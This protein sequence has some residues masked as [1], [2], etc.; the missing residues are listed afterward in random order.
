M[1]YPLKHTEF[2]L[3]N[4]K[5]KAKWS[6]SMLKFEFGEKS[7][8]DLEKDVIYN[9]MCCSCGA[10]AGF[11]NKIEIIDEVATGLERCTTPC[12]ICYSICPRTYF[13][14]KALDNFTF[15]MYRKDPA[16]GYYEKIVMARSTD[17]ELLKVAQNGGVVTS[18]L[19]WALENNEIDSA[20]VARSSPKDQ[21]KPTPVV[22]TTKEE[23]LNAAGSCYTA[24]P[25][26]KGIA[27]AISLGM[28]KIGWVGVPCQVTAFRK[29]QSNKNYELCAENVALTIGLF[30]MET[31]WYKENIQKF[32]KEEF[33][34]ISAVKKFDVAKGKF[35]VY[36]DKEK[37]LFPIKQMDKYVRDGCFWCL[38]LTSEL[39]DVSVGSIGAED[40]WNT[41][42]IRSEKGVSTFENAVNQGYLEVQEIS[43]ESID[44]V[45]KSVNQKKTKN[46][47]NML[48]ETDY[49]KL[50][51]LLMDPMD[52]SVL[53]KDL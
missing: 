43:N 23:V 18:L 41:V 50:Q 12:G 22:A 10:C 26:V 49:I 7:L 53:L 4:N 24:C 3:I 20:V 47:K 36:T 51:Y 42:I 29:L 25:E 2:S 46:L 6:D 1:R 5:T 13:S 28:K 15:G 38:D 17:P 9:N 33:G 19:I 14:I 37:K 40:G 48:S 31:F 21:W 35:I 32:I 39:A 44:K 27:E 8:G 52:L 34:K 45:R 16:L 11:C 30:C